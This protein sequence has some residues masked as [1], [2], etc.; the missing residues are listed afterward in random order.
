MNQQESNRAIEFLV[1]KS[2][3]TFERMYM[4]KYSIPRNEPMWLSRVFVAD[5][6]GIQSR[7]PT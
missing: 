5:L 1:C 2:S 3:I 7:E 4:S 6:I